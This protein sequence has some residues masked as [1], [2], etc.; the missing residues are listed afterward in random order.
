MDE[1]T[2]LFVTVG[3]YSTL[4]ARFSQGKVRPSKGVLIHNALDHIDELEKTIDLL[5]EG[6]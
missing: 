1:Y 5:R 2:R 6:S 3:D 4:K